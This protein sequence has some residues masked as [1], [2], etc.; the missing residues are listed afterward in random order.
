MDYKEHTLFGW[1]EFND[2]VE[3]KRKRDLGR[4][5]NCNPLIRSQMPYPL[6]HRV[7]G[8]EQT[9]EISLQPV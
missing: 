9:R 3:K 6:G 2:I 4:I 8:N 1:N 7:Y 5:R